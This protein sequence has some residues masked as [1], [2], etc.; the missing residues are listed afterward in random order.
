MFLMLLL[1]CHCAK[2]QRTSDEG[3]GTGKRRDTS[4]KSGHLRH[5]R[6]W[7]AS[8]R[9]TTSNLLQDRCLCCPAIRIRLQPEAKQ[10]H[11][12]AG[13]PIA[14]QKNP[15]PVPG[16]TDTVLAAKRSWRRALCLSQWGQAHGASAR[17]QV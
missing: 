12:T 15:A 17:Y 10:T 1:A 14:A 13:A 16:G 11:R 4:G 7:F 9:Q 2:A 5:R 8:L 6:V 3:D